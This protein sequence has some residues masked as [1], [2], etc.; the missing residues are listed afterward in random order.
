MDNVKISPKDGMQMVYV[1]AGEFLLGAKK[2]EPGT[3]KNEQPQCPVFLDAFWI[4]KTPVT[5]AMYV[6]FMNEMGRKK[7]IGGRM[8]ETWDHQEIDFIHI[9]RSAEIW[10]VEKGFKDY[11]VV[12]VN[13]S[14]ARLYSIWAG[15]RLPTEAEWEKAARGTDGRKY[16]W[17][18]QEPD[19]DLLNYNKNKN[20]ITKVGSYPK[21]AS[22]YCA[23]DMEGNVKQW[24]ADYWSSDFYNHMPM[25]NPEKSNPYDGDPDFRIVIRGSSWDQDGYFTRVT[26]RS[27]VSEDYR[28]K[29]IGFR[30]VVSA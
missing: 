3:E 12:M 25:R 2:Y 24:T 10:I 30:C 15:C 13:N 28:S 17:G 9:Y 18:N 5:N 22:P 20:G 16:P 23:L 14:E 11:P 6:K 29:Y 1:P 19:K 8:G 21:G 27:P 7:K 26:Y 4:Y